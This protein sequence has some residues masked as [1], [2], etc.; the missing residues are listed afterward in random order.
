MP[1]QV[2]ET[3]HTFVGLGTL[4]TFVGTQGYG[5]RASQAREKNEQKAKG[6][7]N[8]GGKKGDSKEERYRK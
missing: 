1:P 8:G 6:G 2:P 5:A 3:L 4:H 7:N